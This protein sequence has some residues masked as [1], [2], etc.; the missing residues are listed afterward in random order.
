MR[1]PERF[2]QF[3]RLVQGQPI[4]RCSSPTDAGQRRRPPWIAYAPALSNGSPWHVLAYA[5]RRHRRE[6]DVDTDKRVSS[7]S[8]GTR[9]PRSAPV[10][11]P[12]KH[13][14]H[15]LRLGLIGRLSQNAVFD[16]DGRV[17][18]E[19]GWIGSCAAP[20]AGGPPRP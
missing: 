13:A 16:D 20:S 9:Q 7:R 15:R 19:H 1:Q 10:A 11:A 12:R 2:E 5:I 18:G 3:D 17:G 14:Q 8:R 6:L 4:T